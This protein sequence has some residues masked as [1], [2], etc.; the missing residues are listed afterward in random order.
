MQGRL[1]SY[2]VFSSSNQ[3]LVSLNQ[4]I[5]TTEVYNIFSAAEN[6]YH[7]YPDSTIGLI[8]EALEISEQINYENGI[9]ESY[10]WL[11]YLYQ[12]KGDY[13]NAIDYY[14]KGIEFD[15]N[16]G[17]QLELATNLLNFGSL[18]S[19]MGE[20]KKAA[21]IYRQ[22]LNL[23]LESGDSSMA[24]SVFNN[25]GVYYSDQRQYDSALIYLEQSLKYN[26]PKADPEGY[27]N[28]LGNLGFVN[29][30][31][32]NTKISRSYFWKGLHFCKEFD[33]PKSSAQVFS[34]YSD[35]L[36]EHG[37]LDSAIHYGLKSLEIAQQTNSDYI[38]FY[39]LESLYPAYAE[40][41]D[42]K[43]AFVT[44][45]SLQSVKARLENENAARE[46]IEQSYKLEFEKRILADS[47]NDLSREQLQQA[48]HE[49]DIQRERNVSTWMLGGIGV[50]LMIIL[51]LYIVISKPKKE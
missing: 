33:D 38:S 46:V 28:T 44:L 12:F 31:L 32:G 23:Y 47:I 41:Q 27:A 9:S 45:D 50:T 21:K 30:A 40:K 20:H 37:S 15:K 10:G 26:K 51:A 43:N 3:I 22:S 42:W 35:F 7:E 5:D 1:Y 29:N 19:D 48:K 36:R 6:I 14:K 17:K 8:L 11:G 4:K 13:Q 34:S 25:L 49:A 2:L 39:A 16:H 18:V 24:G